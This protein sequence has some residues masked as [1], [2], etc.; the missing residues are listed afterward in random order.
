MSELGNYDPKAIQERCQRLWKDGRFFETEPDSGKQPYSIVM[1]PP[2]VTG[3]LHL[4]HAL[5][6]TLQDILIRRKRMQGFAAVWMAGADHAGIATQ[7]VVEKNLKE[8][9]NKNRHDIGRDE[10]VKRIWAWKDQ[11]EN[12]IIEQLHGIGCSF[13]ERRWRFTLD[14]RCSKAVRHAFFKMFREGLIFRGKRLV[15]W[16]VQLQTA[17]A[18]DELEDKEVDGNLWHFR[19]PVEGTSEHLVIATTRPETMLGDTAAAVHPTDPRYLHLIGKQVRLP[20]MDRL[21]PIIADGKLVDPKFGTGVVKVTPAHDPNDWACGQRNNLPVLNILTPEGRINENGCKYAGLSRF[22]ARKAVVADLDALGLLESIKPHKHNVPHSDRS[23][24]AIEPYLSDQWFV[25]MAPLADEALKA[26]EDGRIKFHPPRYADNYL[27]W[28][29]ERRDWCI[30]RQLWWG[31]RIPVWRLTKLAADEAAAKSLGKTLESKLGPPEGRWAMQF[32]K[33]ESGFD[34]QVCL[35]EDDATLAATLESAGLERDPD[36]LDTWFSSGLWP[37]SVFGWPDESADLKFFYPTSVLSTAREIITLWVARMVAMGL[38]CRG[39]IPFCDVYIHAVIL[40]GNGERMSK[41]KGNGVDPFDIIDAYG[42]DALRYTLAHL[43]TETQDVRMPVTKSKLP[44]GREV[45]TSTKFELGRN[46]GTKIYNASKL[47]L[48]NLE[49]FEPAKLNPAELP[50]EDRWILHRLDETVEAA[51]AALDGYRFSEYARLMYDFVWGSLCD[52][53]LEMVKPRWRGEGDAKKTAQRVSAF[54]LDRTLRLLHPMMPFVSEEVWQAM[55]SAALVREIDG[56]GK[57]EDSLVSAKW[58][59]ADAALRSPEA[60]ERVAGLQQVIAAVRNMR[61]QYN[62]NTKEEIA[63]LVE[64]PQPLADYL[65][66]SKGMALHLA[67]VKEWTCGPN[68]SRPSGSAAAILPGARVYLPFGDLIDRPA[69]IAKQQ[70]KKTDLEKRLAGSRSKL[71]NQA[72]VDKAPADVVE[73][74]RA[75]EKE[76]LDQMAAIDAVILDLQA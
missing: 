32:E 10:L 42:A 33:G 35:L 25:R 30:S 54:V 1:P 34:L 63:V 45:N 49:G 37:I 46:F 71:Q 38:F 40:D 26:V 36:V 53:Y 48:A 14:E 50:D 57:A 51:T 13:D 43:A 6:N 19:Y 27:R 31:H 66:A 11:C 61:S 24:T 74:L 76:F 7:A 52:W 20:L 70:K 62:I 75:S 39:D 23:K 56:S 17:V 12:R 4:G 55:K 60:A 9:E 72:F 28:L 15:N 68:V 73:Q 22:E 47:I 29:G 67:K 59:I 41:S 2:N 8:K 44:D 18:D 65:T 69:E 3:V 5:N 21:I 16:D 64:C 58:P